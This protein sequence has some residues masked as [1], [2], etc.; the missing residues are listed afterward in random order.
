MVG[1]ETP[2]PAL[3]GVREGS[4]P[5][6]TDLGELQTTMKNNNNSKA[7]TQ[8]HCPRNGLCWRGAVLLHA[9]TLPSRGAEGAR[10]SWRPRVLLFGA[11]WKQRWHFH[12]PNACAESG[13]PEGEGEADLGHPTIPTSPERDFGGFACA[14]AGGQGPPPVNHRCPPHRS[15]SAGTAPLAASRGSV[16]ASAGREGA[17]DNQMLS[18]TPGKG[19]NKKNLCEKLVLDGHEM[20]ISFPSFIPTNTCHLGAAVKGKGS[21]DGSPQLS[22][23]R[24]GSGTA[25]AASAPPLRM[26]SDPYAG[27]PGG[28]GH[29]GLY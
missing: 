21:P 3:P 10:G 8:P 16:P 11:C 29:P 25:R 13:S 6:G 5:L 1:S 7:P 26:R 20:L 28:R 4:A 2:R 17:G 12:L 22:P 18:L 14:G 19:T 9:S 15:G 23:S 24:A 27:G